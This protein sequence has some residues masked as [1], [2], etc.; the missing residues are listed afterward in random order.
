M[1]ARGPKPMTL[2]TF[3]VLC[4]ATWIVFQ[5]ELRQGGSLDLFWVVAFLLV[6]FMF[7]GTL[8]SKPKRQSEE[9]E[10]QGLPDAP[11]LRRETPMRKRPRRSR[12]LDGSVSQ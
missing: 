6:F 10:V 5:A 4:M 11:Q 8:A 1:K 7:W 3:F 9:E 12:G 2:L